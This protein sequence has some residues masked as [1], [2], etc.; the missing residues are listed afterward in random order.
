MNCHLYRESIHPYSR[1][2]CL[3]KKNFLLFF[4]IFAQ[5]D[6]QRSSLNT[7]ILATGICDDTINVL[8]IRIVEILCSKRFLISAALVTPTCPATH[9]SNE[10]EPQPHRAAA[11]APGYGALQPVI[12]LTL[13]KASDSLCSSS[14][15][16]RWSGVKERQI[17]KTRSTAQMEERKPSMTVCYRCFHRDQLRFSSDN[18]GWWK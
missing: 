16:C 5:L 12:P 4:V 1:F 2:H 7:S 6:G 15:Y 11:N 13:Q 18:V 10:T 14:L 9:R 17:A 3:T 8:L